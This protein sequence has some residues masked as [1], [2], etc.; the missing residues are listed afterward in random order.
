MSS[1][2]PLIIRQEIHTSSRF[3]ALGQGSRYGRINIHTGRPRWTSQSEKGGLKDWTLVLDEF[4]QRGKL[5]LEFVPK[6]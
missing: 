2:S 3:L 4:V 1:L 6:T 5:V